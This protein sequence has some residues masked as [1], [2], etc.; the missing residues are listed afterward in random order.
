MNILQHQ[1]DDLPS[2]IH[3]PKCW[4][5][6]DYVCASHHDSPASG[7]I[8]GHLASLPTCTCLI[9]RNACV[10][11]L[12]DARLYGMLIIMIALHLEASRTILRHC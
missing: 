6:K 11:V 2:K 12:V 4:R 9:C 10:G 1:T 5:V 7:D 3:A 8:S